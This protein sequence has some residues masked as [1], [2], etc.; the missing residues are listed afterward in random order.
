MTLL[1]RAPMSVGLCF[2]SFFF[3]PSLDLSQF[4]PFCFELAYQMEMEIET[5]PT[6]PD[7]FTRSRH[8][9]TNTRIKKDCISNP[10]INTTILNVAEKLHSLLLE[11]DKCKTT[12]L[13][14]AQWIHFIYETGQCT[15]DTIIIA[16][17]YCERLFNKNKEVSLTEKNWKSLIAI[18]FML[19][20]KVW[21][22]LSMMNSDFACFLPFSLQQINTWERYFLSGLN[23]DVSVKPS[24]YAQMFFEFRN[25]D[26]NSLSGQLPQ[27]CYYDEILFSEE[28]S[29]RR[30]RSNSTMST[31]PSVSMRCSSGNYRLDFN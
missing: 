7:Y 11:A 25:V 23:F 8:N 5:Q 30:K 2:F 18:S 1:I 28:K 22:D 31:S 16:F 12:C 27:P 29:I 24:H 14:F 21:D 19:S 17:I 20:S 4:E 10:N 3:S 6:V 15:V 13:E 26:D 9:S